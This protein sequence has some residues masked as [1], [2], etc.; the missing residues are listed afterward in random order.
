MGSFEAI[1]RLAVTLGVS[2]PESNEDVFNVSLINSIN[3][4]AKRVYKDMS[5]MHIKNKD[6]VVALNEIKNLPSVR[7][8]E[9]STI[10]YLAINK[11]KET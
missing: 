9:G 3:R 8:D 5:K 4:S 10:A 7:M 6:L 11:N 2:C 1:R